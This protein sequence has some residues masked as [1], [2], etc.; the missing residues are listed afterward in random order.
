M[1]SLDLLVCSFF[2]LFLSPFTLFYLCLGGVEEALTIY[3]LKKNITFLFKGKQPGMITTFG[4]FLR[5]NSVNVYFQ[6]DL[7]TVYSSLNYRVM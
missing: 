6:E 1:Q 3:L 5:N 7:S 4:F 2:C